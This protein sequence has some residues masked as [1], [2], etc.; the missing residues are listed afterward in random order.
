M[1]PNNDKKQLPVLA[2]GIALGAAVAFP[3]AYWLLRPSVPDIPPEVRVQSLL[4]QSQQAMASARPEQSLAVM[5]EASRIDPKNQAV[6]NNLC[7]AFTLLKRYDE[8]IAACE[9][10][11]LLK[12]GF[13]LA[14]NN[15][16]WATAE[17]SKALAPA[18]KAP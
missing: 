3:A 4:D 18:A 16:A 6:Q 7:V 5:L 13:Q 12:P 15:L 2:M 9:A 11:L 14:R 1:L 10:A 17:R 8:G